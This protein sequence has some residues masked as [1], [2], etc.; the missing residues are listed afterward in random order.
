MVNP[1]RADAQA[2]RNKRGV[3]MKCSRQQIYTVISAVL[4]LIGAVFM[5]INTFVEDAVWAFWVGLCLAVLATSVYVLLVLENRKVIS[6][7]IENT[8]TTPVNAKDEN[9]DKS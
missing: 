6:K 7:K 9:K 1:V 5:L 8:A 2:N 4:F 3:N